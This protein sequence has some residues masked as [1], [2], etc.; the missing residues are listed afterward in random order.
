[1]SFVKYLAKES[2]NMFNTDIGSVLSWFCNQFTVTVKAEESKRPRDPRPFLE[3]FGTRYV[4]YGNAYD[5]LHMSLLSKDKKIITLSTNCRD[6]FNEAIR[7]FITGGRTRGL[8]CSTFCINKM[9]R[10]NLR[11]VLM[12]DPINPIF[13]GVK[14]GL[15]LANMYGKV[16]GWKKFRLARCLIRSEENFPPLEC[17]AVIGDK[18]WQRTPQFI[19]MLILLIR[20][21]L[22]HE[23]PSWIQD[24]YSLQG[25]WH[26]ILG[27]KDIRYKNNDF[28]TFLYNSYDIL[29]TLV[30]HEREIFPHDQDGGYSIELDNFHLKSGLYSLVK[31]DNPTHP[32]S[33]MK[34]SELYMEVCKNEGRL[35][36]T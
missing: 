6:Y 30:A 10:D 34:L 29:L 14:N 23:V 33:A 15:R 19:S 31:Y 25:Y 21:C 7:W 24:A 18:N 13:A 9:D 16:A 36:T 8:H 26:E 17:Y 4:G 32:K 1:M 3:T 11:M 35:N 27:D 28:E 12:S 2:K 5:G 22:Y 20:V